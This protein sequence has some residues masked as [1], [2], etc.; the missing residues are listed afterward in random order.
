MYAAQPRIT[1]ITY[2]MV[3]MGLAKHTK[4]KLYSEDKILNTACAHE[5]EN[6]FHLDNQLKS[7]ADVSLVARF[8]GHTFYSL[9]LWAIHHKKLSQQGLRDVFDILAVDTNAH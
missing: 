8:I 3:R 9:I 5:Q 2:I 1:Y 4:T 6:D 7:I